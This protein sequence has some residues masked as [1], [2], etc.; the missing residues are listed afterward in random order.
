M[1]Y[2]IPLKHS[3]SPFVVI[4]GSPDSLHPTGLPERLNKI[5]HKLSPVARQDSGKPT[6]VKTVNVASATLGAVMLDR[7][8]ALG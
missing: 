4:G 8:V 7:A 3:H 1:V 2:K 5:R 6:C